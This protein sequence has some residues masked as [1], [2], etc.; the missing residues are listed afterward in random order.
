MTVTPTH[1]A[2]STVIEIGLAII[3]G[4]MDALATA[5]NSA[6]SA[7]AAHVTAGHPTINYT[8]SEIDALMA[9]LDIL[10]EATVLAGMIKGSGTNKAVD[11]VSVGLNGSNELE[12]KDTGIST[13]K[14][15]NNAVTAGKLEYK[16]WKGFVSQAGTCAPTGNPLSNTL[17]GTI[18][19]SRAATGYYLGYLPG[20]FTTGK[21]ICFIGLGQGLAHYIQCYWS[22]TDHILIYTKDLAGNLADSILSNHPL[23]I[24]I[25]A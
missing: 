14:L 10:G 12:V 2:P 15:A 16:V 20:V 18:T 19:W 8:K 4:D 9:A 6:V 11:G 24:N 13:A 7:Q 23:E 25:Y 5:I 22:D 17:G 1:L 21:T 3:N